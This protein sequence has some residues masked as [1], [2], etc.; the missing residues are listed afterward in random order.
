MNREGSKAASGASDRETEEALDWFTR[1]RG[2]DVTPDD[3]AAFEAWRGAA[4]GR[5]MAYRRVQTFWESDA[6]ETAL[7][8][9]ERST[10]APAGAA[11][12]HPIPHRRPVLNIAGPG[13]FQERGDYG[14]VVGEM[15]RVPLADGSVIRLNTAS[16]V[17]LAMD[18]H[19]RGVRLLRGE[20]YFDVAHDA[21]RPFEVEAGTVRVTVLGTAFAVR[22]EGDE[23]VVAVR[24]GRVS[25]RRDGGQ[26]PAVM[27]KAGELM[28]V[29]PERDGVPVPFD[30][31]AEFAWL[32]GRIAFEDRPLRAVL[33][34][35]ERY[36][37]GWIIVVGDTL[38]DAH[39]S[40]NYRLDDPVGIANSLAGAAKG[41]ALHLPGGVIVV[42]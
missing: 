42:H 16:A 1:L 15:A 39:V 33:S 31:A 12:N 13:L 38:G 27:L 41:T 37:D 19:R 7:L 6:F 11:V 26:G 36:Y 17:A 22:R 30:T 24:R 2:A 5:A 32:N 25:V 28:R 10:V 40:G 20:G 23:I 14:T 3:R 29:A 35:V 34:Q 21:G 8:E 9:V 18:G 4:P